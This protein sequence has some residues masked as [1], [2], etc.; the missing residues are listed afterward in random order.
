MENYK[1]FGLILAAGLS[2]RMH[3]F[4]P[5]LD[6]KGK[7]FIV[8][9]VEKLYPVTE[10]IIVVTGYNSFLLEK[11]LRENLSE[12]IFKN[13][14]TV[15]NEKY[16]SGMFGSLQKGIAYCRKANWVLYHFTDQPSLPKKF[17]SDFVKQID[18]NTDWIQPVG[19]N[20][21][22][23]PI[24]LGEK[25]IGKILNA[26]VDS[27]LRTISKDGINKKLWDCNY[28]EIFNDI[29]TTEDY[30]NLLL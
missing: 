27:D 26:T 2:G 3:S 19:G 29:D 21:K 23:H 24:L 15:F 12:K 30:E 7:S 6:Y 11:H 1:I 22:G 20:R 16:E 10:K 13:V 28:I 14:K 9:I 17:Y 5:L 4:K 8:N 25:V 18:G